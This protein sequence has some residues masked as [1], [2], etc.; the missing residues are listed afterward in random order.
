V[1]RIVFVCS[2]Y[3]GD[4]E[5]NAAYARRAVRSCLLRG[6]VPIAPHLMYPGALDDGVKDERE[7][8]LSACVDL[9][10]R[11]DALVVFGDFGVSSG[12]DREIAA[13][14]LYRILV[15]NRCLPPE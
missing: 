6:E 12:M 10:R 1:G 7:I 13:A 14:H 4:V 15:E 9:L 11:C 5:R 3:R 8:A 2:P